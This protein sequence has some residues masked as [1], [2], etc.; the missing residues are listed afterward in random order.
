M[1]KK[2][3]NNECATIIEGIN[4]LR[5]ALAAK[6][7]KKYEGPFKIIEVKSPS[8]YILDSAERGS[9]K[10][11]MTHVTELKSCVHLRNRALSEKHS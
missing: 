1:L 2:Q 7:C 10:L 8:I 9:R 4:M 11:T 5:T 6:M 3:V